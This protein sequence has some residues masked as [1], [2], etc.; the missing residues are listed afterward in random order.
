MAEGLVSRD[1]LTDQPVD[2]VRELGEPRIER[3]LARRAVQLGEPGVERHGRV[4]LRVGPRRE[5]AADPALLGGELVHRGREAVADE[6][7]GELGLPAAGADRQDPID[8]ERGGGA[9]GSA[10]DRRHVD[11]TPDARGRV[12]RR[13]GGE[14][15][16]VGH[17]GDPA[18]GEDLA[19]AHRIGRQ[20]VRVD[21]LPG[22]FRQRAV[23]AEPGLGRGRGEGRPAFRVGEVAAPR[24]EVDAEVV[25]RV[26]PVGKGGK[27]RAVAVLRR[28]AEV[29][30]DVEVLVPARR[31]RQRPAVA[32]LEGG[33][34]RRVA[35]QVLAVHQALRPV[36]VG[37]PV[38]RTADPLHPGERGTPAGRVVG[39]RLGR[40]ERGE[41]EQVAP[42][43]RHRQPVGH[44]EADVPLA[45]LQAL[46]PEHGLVERLE[47]ELLLVEVAAN[48]GRPPEVGEL[49]PERRFEGPELADRHLERAHPAPCCRACFL[50]VKSIFHSY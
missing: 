34:L 21:D 4:D 8:V 16:P 23:E 17:E 44:D 13:V 3:Q 25:D 29:G 19:R 46:P 6:A 12:A 2:D 47:V 36:V 24:P 18:L 11:E 50:Q 40:E 38:E 49:P 42:P 20:R 43:H 32:G 1:R 31:H 48:A 26:V 39:N 22:P 5:A 45:P 9:A 33:P 35:E 14:A 15:E 41:V 37:Q 28:P 27:D 30:D 10:R 7:V